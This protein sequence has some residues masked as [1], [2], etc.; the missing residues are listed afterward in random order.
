MKTLI[1]LKS[2]ILLTITLTFGVS[3]AQVGIGT[4]TPTFTLHVVNTGNIGAV[5]LTSSENSGTNGLGFDAINYGTGNGYN[6][7]EGITFGNYSG[8]FGLHNSATNFGYGGF[9]ATNNVVGAWGAYVSGDFNVTGTYYNISDLRFKKDVSAM[10][11]N[12]LDKLMALNP[13]SYKFDSDKYPGLSLDK[14][15]LH[16]GFLAQELIEVFPALVNTEKAIPNPTKK[17]TSRSESDNVTGYYLVDYVGMIPLLVKGI[18]EQQS[19]IDTQNTKIQ[20]LEAKLLLLESK[21]NALIEN[22]D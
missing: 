20:D 7:I 16:Y 14:N 2:L 19:I 22:Q 4:T 15:K 18:Q 10:E 13:T 3:H 21:V 1:N 9:F 17:T 5:P 8:I 11:A 12:T 6:A